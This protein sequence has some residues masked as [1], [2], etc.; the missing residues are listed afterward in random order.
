MAVTI[1]STTDELY[2]CSSRPRAVRRGEKVPSTRGTVGNPLGLLDRGPLRRER[3]CMRLRGAEPATRGTGGLFG[4]LLGLLLEHL[5]E[6][7]FGQSTGRSRGDLLHRSEVHVQA[8]PAVPERPLGDDSAASSRN[9]SSSSAVKR[10]VLM[11]RSAHQLRRNRHALFVSRHTR[12]AKHTANRELT[13]KTTTG[14]CEPTR[15]RGHLVFCALTSCVHLDHDVP[16]VG[17]C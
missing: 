6:R 5:L 17:H 1:R 11:A 8:R 4:H 14:R 9:R 2:P 12:T 3:P 13:S 10:G 15:P 16:N 7:S